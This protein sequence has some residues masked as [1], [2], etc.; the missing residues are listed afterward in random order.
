MELQAIEKEREY[1]E[2]KKASKN[3]SKDTNKKSHSSSEDMK[4]GTKNPQS[5]REQVKKRV[6]DSN[7]IAVEPDMKLNEIVLEMK[8]NAG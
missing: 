5:I 3:G 6:D 1:K 8:G 2:A 4:K 7:N